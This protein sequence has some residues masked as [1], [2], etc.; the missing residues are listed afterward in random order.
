[1]PMSVV[2]EYFPEWPR[3]EK[4]Q[5]DYYHQSWE[6]IG[7]GETVWVRRE[8]ESEFGYIIDLYD[9]KRLVGFID[10]SSGEQVYDPYFIPDDDP[11]SSPKLL[12]QPREGVL[13]DLETAIDAL[14]GHMRAVQEGR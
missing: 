1:M 12:I 9:D 10:V 7:R 8:F 13:I 4:G 11:E 3:G 14:E 5:V 2:G 6:R